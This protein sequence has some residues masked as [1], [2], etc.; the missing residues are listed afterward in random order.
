[1][2][3][4]NIKEKYKSSIKEKYGVDNLFK[5]KDIIEKML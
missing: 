4:E 1:M 2:K 3:D 5:N